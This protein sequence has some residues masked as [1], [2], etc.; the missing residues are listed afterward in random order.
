MQLTHIEERVRSE[1]SLPNTFALRPRVPARGLPQRVV[2]PNF[3]AVLVA[4]ARPGRPGAADGPDAG[5][6]YYLL[7]F[8]DMWTDAFAVPGTRTTGSGAGVFVIVPCG[9]GGRNLAM[10]RSGPDIGALADRAHADERAGGLRGVHAFQDALQLTA[11]DGSA[12]STAVRPPRRHRHPSTCRSVGHRQQDA[13]GG[14]LRLRRTTSRAVPAASTDFSIVRASSRG[15]GSCPE[16]PSTHRFGTIGREALEAGAKDA[17]AA[18]A[19][20]GQAGPHRERMEHQHRHD[21]RLR[22]LLPQARDRDDGGTG[23]ESA[24]CRLPDR[25]GGCRGTGD[26]R[27]QGLRPAL[28]EGAAVAARPGVLV[29]DRLRRQRIPVPESAGPFAL[30]RP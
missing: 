11:L 25:R 4:L 24:G 30:Q 14:V 18:G 27:R 23:R 2:A 19:A 21:G 3:D 17:R 9:V 28:R 8:L 12:L 16:S 7:P 26:R 13:G 6:R 22:Q 1:R 20:S 5:D 10:P 29:H 15:S